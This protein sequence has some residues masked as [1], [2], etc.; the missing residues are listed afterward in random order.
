MVRAL[1]SAHQG[2]TR[3]YYLRIDLDETVRRHES[4]ALAAEVP[5]AKLREWFC[6]DDLLGL[7][8]EIVVDGRAPLDD[9][10]QSILADIGPV[11]VAADTHGARFL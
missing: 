4:G 11:P 7:P 3:L 6:A 5:S 1:V 8:G 10:E 2:P 9:V